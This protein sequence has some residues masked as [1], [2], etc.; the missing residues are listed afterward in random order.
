MKR[1]HLFLPLGLGI[2]L[3]GCISF[4]GKTPPYFLRLTAAQE[5][6]AGPSRSAAAGQVITVVP[7]VANQELATPRVPVHSGNN[8]VAY[9]KDAQWVET[10]SALFG[11]L[12][13]ETISVHGGRVVL[14]SRQFNLDPGLRLTGTLQSF[15]LD[16]DQMQAVVVYDA[17]L[18]RTSATVETRRFAAR[19]PVAALDGPSAAAAL[20]Q[21]ANQVAS[22]VAAWVG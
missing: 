6:P 10:P 1:S 11:R 22:D 4:G 14:D 16:A 17:V 3:S 7:P 2:A 8:Q 13:S 20:N 18:A 15:G 12:I 21:A 19:V 9:L 5:Q